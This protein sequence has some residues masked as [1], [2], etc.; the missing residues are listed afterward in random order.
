VAGAGNFNV[1]E[2]R[3]VNN[4][5]THPGDS[6]SIN[7]SASSPWRIELRATFT[8]ALPIILTQIA[9]VG[10]R[11]V[12]TIFLGRLGTPELAAGALGGNFYFLFYLFGLGV[13]VS[14]SALAARAHGA[15]N[16]DEVRRFVRQGLWAATAVGAPFIIVLWQIEPILK[17]LGQSTENSILASDYMQMM[18]WG[19]IPSLGIVAL[20]SFIS[21]L[22]R[23]RSVLVITVLGVSVNSIG[24]YLLIFGNHGFPALGIAGAGLSSSIV[25]ILMFS[26]LLIYIVRDNQFRQ[27]AILHRIWH[28][29]WAKFFEIFRVGL[30]IGTSLLFEVG[31]FF[32]ASILL[33]LISTEQLAA[34]Q[35]AMQCISFTFM[36]PLGLAQAATIRVGLAAGAQDRIAVGRSGWMA[37]LLGGIF[38]VAASYVFWFHPLPL[39]YVFLGERAADSPEVVKFAVLL[40]AVAAIFQLADGLQA[41]AAGALRGLRDTRTPMFIALFG[42]WIVGFP[43]SALFGFWLDFEGV[44]VWSG[45]AVGL[46]VVAGLLLVRFYNWR[47]IPGATIRT[48]P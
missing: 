1:F 28:T 19:L 36:V 11:A 37:I 26:A 40:L 32:S 23:P 43:V 22:S 14:V 5:P 21:A 7:W 47:K 15:G 48:Q 6:T 44:G 39:I 20:R 10:I 17:L 18:M 35:I 16:A 46:A 8:L 33:G 31:L 30:P 34:H 24:D 4:Q 3:P 45:L 41:L 38:M 27:Y 29:D 12:D 25:N 13:V 9:Q 42:F 2:R